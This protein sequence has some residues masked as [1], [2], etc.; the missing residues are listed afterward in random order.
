MSAK[1]SNFSVS[2][3]NR[4]KLKSVFEKNGYKIKEIQEKSRVNGGKEFNDKVIILSKL[5]APCSETPKEI[6]AMKAQLLKAIK[7][8]ESGNSCLQAS[9]IEV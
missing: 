7:V 6:S 5:K 4:S 2:E 1:N 8:Q 9:T 3:I